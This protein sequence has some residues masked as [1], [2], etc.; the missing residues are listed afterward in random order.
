MIDFVG[1]RKWFFVFSG[2]LVVAGIIILCTVGLKLGVDFTAGTSLTIRPEIT[3][4]QAKFRDAVSNIGYPRATVQLTGNK[5]FF[6]R[7]PELTDKEKEAFVAGLNKEVGKVT[8]LDYYSVSPSVAADTVRDTG[9]ALA[10]AAV[11]ILLYIA[12]AFRRMRHSFRW[13]VCTLIPLLH[14]VFIVISIF[15]ILGWVLGVEIDALFITGILAVVGFSD[16]NT[17]VVFD[18]IRD[19]RNSNP[20]ADFATLVNS[21]INQ[22]LVRSFGTSLTALFVI[23]ALFLFGGITI[24]NFMLVLLVGIIAGTYSASCISP[25]LLVVWENRDW[26][27]G[28]KKTAIDA[29]KS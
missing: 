27:F 2:V 21:S 24:R 16:N 13:G 26:G 14:D 19:N 29:N 5:D 22:T 10:V 7:L 8:L 23:S 3:V 20:K 11:G 1:N 12:W 15:A 4:D 18:R 6:V 25:Q 9:I 17:I 28:K